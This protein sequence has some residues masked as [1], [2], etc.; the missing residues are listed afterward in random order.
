VGVWMIPLYLLHALVSQEKE[1]PDAITDSKQPIGGWKPM[2]PVFPYD[3][4]KSF[5]QDR[6]YN[7]EDPTYL[8]E[9]KAWELRGGDSTWVSIKQ[10]K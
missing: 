1:H 3:R 4:S 7:Y 5:W 10:P 6:L 2:P 9:L 8:A